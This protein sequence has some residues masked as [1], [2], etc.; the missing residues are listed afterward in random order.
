MR[1]G[2]LKHFVQIMVRGEVGR[3]DLNEPIFGYTVWRELFCKMEVR[4]GKEQFDA[5]SNQRFTETV[6]HFTFRFSDA[7]GIEETM[8]IQYRGR[9]HEIRNII[10][11]LVYEESILVE[12]AVEN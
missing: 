1:A 2:E 3:T 12:A 10:P 11:D 6:T 8:T 9:K 5:A 4:R 7:D